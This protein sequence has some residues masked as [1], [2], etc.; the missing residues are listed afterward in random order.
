MGN[1]YNYHL[2][3]G[4]TWRYVVVVVENNPFM[5]SNVFF[6]PVTTYRHGLIQ[7]G[8][9]DWGLEEPHKE[10]LRAS[11]FFNIFIDSGVNFLDIK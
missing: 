2:I 4:G 11:Q 5:G 8:K 10:Q 1:N 9:Q 3:K 7:N 6:Y